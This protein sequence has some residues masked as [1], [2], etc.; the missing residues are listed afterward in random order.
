[1]VAQVSPFQENDKGT[2]LMQ[3]EDSR[4]TVIVLMSCPGRMRVKIPGLYRSA[5]EKDRLEKQLS[6]HDRIHAAYANPL[7]G[8]VLI[9]FDASLSEATL[10]M[11]LGLKAK[12][13]GQIPSV[14][15]LRNAKRKGRLSVSPAAPHQEARPQKEI[16][17]AWHS[18]EAETVIASHHT[19]RESG[20]ASQEAEERLKQGANL[21]PSK[22][23][24]S[25]SEILRAQFANLPSALLGVSAGL[26]LLT[27]GIAEA[28]AIAAVM[29][30]NAG[31]GFTTERRAEQ[32]IASLSELIDDI[33]PVLRDGYT[34]DIPASH[35]V[36]GDM[37]V[38]A[39]GVRIAGDARV[40]QSNGVHVDESA[41]TGESHYIAKR[42][43]V[44]DQQIALAE[45]SNM[46]YMGTAVTAGQGL[47]VVVGTALNTEIGAIQA[48]MNATELPKTPLQKQLDHL[49][50]RSVTISLGVCGAVFIL[51]MLRGQG[52]LRM[53]KT[54]VSLAVAAV[55]EGL[56]TVATTSL[57]R[58]IRLMRE[59]EMLVRRLHAIETLGAIHSLCF[60]K[61]GTLTMNRMS[62]IAVET[63]SRT[64]SSN[65][66]M[67][68]SEQVL[69]LQRD[70][71]LSRLLTICVLSNEIHIRDG[72]HFPATMESAS[73]DSSASLFNGSATE[74]ALVQLALDAG[75]HVEDLRER[76]PVMQSELRAEKRNYVKT[77]HSDIRTGHTII[78]VKGNPEE[79]L[80]LCTH[81]ETEDG[82]VRLDDALC[83][84]IM[85]R[86]QEMA[87]RQLRV[88]GFAYRDDP[89]GTGAENGLIW[90]GL[91]GLADPLRPG[92]K[93]VIEALHRAGIRT[94][95]ITGDQPATALAIGEALG[96]GRRDQLRIVEAE[97][98]ENPQ[99]NQPSRKRRMTDTDIFARVTPA[100]KLHIVQALQQRGEVVGM[101]GD[102]VNDGPALQAANVGIA[103]GLHG[104][105]LARSAADVV[106]KDDR[107]ETVLEAIKQGRTISA[108]IEKS[109]HFLLSSN[110]SEILVVLGA[111]AAG[112]PVPLSPVQLLWI[113][114]L[115]DVLPAVALAAE[116]A[117]KDIMQRP[118]RAAGKSLI[119]NAEL[120]RYTAEGTAL[121]SGTLGSYLYG[122]LRYGVGPQAGTLA[123][124]SLVLGQLLHAL[125]CR[126]ERHAALSRMGNPGS[127]KLNL[128]IG[129]SIGL[130]I[131]ANL[132][133][134]LRKMLGIAEMGLA[135]MAVILAGAGVP[136]LFNE[137]TKARQAKKIFEY[138]EKLG[139]L[140]VA[141]AGAGAL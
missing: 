140:I 125:S 141:E 128:A 53:L 17:P 70:S 107:L 129:G 66:D 30:L 112:L 86:N 13:R 100:R 105:D 69:Q 84:S 120:K 87:Q 103:M 101:T 91:A 16:Y 102:G 78:A 50:N 18:H 34:Q 57:A 117:E 134:G 2:S 76:F 60:D 130:Q 27:G 122:A 98:G 62:V 45:R 67:P 54:A 93:T 28:I 48:L 49:G 132:I 137:A 65:G 83:K 4:N 36:P 7:T 79:V 131:I 42:D 8:N 110:L 97:G 123:F 37:L 133:P 126:S 55:P 12:N 23:T 127:N 106:L 136:L 41:L 135:D 99:L 29:A 61:T 82:I 71:A 51:G 115:S 75:L 116:P 19:S 88:L 44:L 72:Q 77:V 90:L 22:R 3:R 26:S 68:W 32:T 58:G 24:R 39:P 109:V 6:R 40:I 63:P 9:L 124:N 121:A 119:G 35:V 33:I 5:S 14:H 118:P 80:A 56:P 64:Y 113:N 1:M 21:L 10:L 94:S 108:N 52:L 139:E 89:D 43:A 104:T 81:C 138:E 74:N 38:L 25:S 47:A 46:V 92:A 59:R 96:L 31:I 73:A 85:A 15:E 95:M 111:T 114:L 20:L 11:A